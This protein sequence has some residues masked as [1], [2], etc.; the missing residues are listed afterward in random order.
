MVALSRIVQ[1]E[2]V[3][4]LAVASF[5]SLFYYFYCNDQTTP[6]ALGSLY[7][8]MTSVVIISLLLS[9]MNSLRLKKKK[10]DSII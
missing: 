3:S 8:D 4:S 10:S 9:L 6:K 2:K 5:F 1:P 7:T